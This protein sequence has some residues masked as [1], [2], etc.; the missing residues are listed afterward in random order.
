MSAQR[1]RAFGRYYARKGLRISRSELEPL[2]EQR[3]S[4]WAARYF[5][6]S[7]DK[8][9][10]PSRITLPESTMSASIT[11]LFDCINAKTDYRKIAVE[12][13]RNALRNVPEHRVIQAQSR[14]LRHLD[15]GVPLGTAI[16]RACAWARSATD[17]SEPTPP[18]AA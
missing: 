18:R 6:L 14:A 2:P 10:P 11:N 15:R 3:M 16:D 9:N 4:S 17:P 13:V 12:D 1:D 5:R 8:R 7:P